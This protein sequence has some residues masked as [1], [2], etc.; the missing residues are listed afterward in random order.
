MSG[1][2]ESSSG[3]SDTRAKRRA[4]REMR[5]GCREVYFELLAAGHSLQTIAKMHK[6]SVDVVRRAV[7]RAIAERRLD[8]PERFVHLQVA[9]LNKALQVADHFLTR[10]DHRAVGPYLK[11]VAELDRYHGLAVQYRRLAAPAGLAEPR[12][13]PPPFA[14]TLAAPALEAD[15]PTVLNV[16]ELA[17]A[18]ESA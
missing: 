11:V 6:V 3:R 9:R 1:P 7:D 14:L 2:S 8:A 5:A 15:A 10:A 13:S 4:R 17:A 16:A 12:P 18:P